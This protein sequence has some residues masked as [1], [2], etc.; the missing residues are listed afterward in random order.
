[1]HFD[2]KRYW[3]SPKP[4]ENTITVDAQPEPLSERIILE[5]KVMRQELLASQ[6]N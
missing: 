2:K 4:Q 1:M 3:L 5:K 6:I